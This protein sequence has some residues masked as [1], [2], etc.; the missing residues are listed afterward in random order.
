[1]PLSTDSL[2][3]SAKIGSDAGVLREGGFSVSY[4][5]L[6]KLTSCPCKKA[7]G[8]SQSSSTVT[9]AYG[10]TSIPWQENECTSFN[11]ANM[12]S[13][14]HASNADLGLGEGRIWDFEV[15]L[16]KSVNIKK[17]MYDKIPINSL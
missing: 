3:G 10:S 14:Q 13:E 17:S 6:D 11:L 1:M 4:Q 16:L 12:F 2:Q 8:Q 5:R 9:G 15:A 7:R